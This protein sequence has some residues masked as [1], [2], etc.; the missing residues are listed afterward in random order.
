MTGS[1]NPHRGAHSFFRIDTYYTEVVWYKNK[2][3]D[4]GMFIE[5]SL[6]AKL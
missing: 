2:G 4:D 1:S 5:N 3:E 6:R